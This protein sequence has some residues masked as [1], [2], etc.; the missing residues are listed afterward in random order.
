MPT[1]ALLI[2]NEVERRRVIVQSIL[3]IE[4]DDYLSTFHLADNTKFTC[5]K[6]L[7]EIANSLP[8]HFFQI[9]RKCIVN[10]NEIISVKRKSRKI[11]LTNSEELTI[12]TRRLN[13]FN[14]TLASQSTTFAR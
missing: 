2:G 14:E 13:D 5:S 12:S 6:S 9:N 4:I 8:D 7:C 3:Y 11:T 10:L 1:R